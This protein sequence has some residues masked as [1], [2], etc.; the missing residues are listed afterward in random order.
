MQKKP[1]YITTSIAYVNGEPHIG[2]A[3]ELLEADALARYHRLKG[4]DV[5][6]LTGTDEHGSKLAQ[7]ATNLNMTPQELCDKNAAKFLELTKAL[8]CTNDDFIRTSDQKRHWPAVN[9]LWKTLV[10]KGDIY[11]D[12]YEGL[13]CIGCEKFITEKELVDGKCPLHDREPEKLKEENYFFRL[14]KYSK[15]IGELIR[16][17]ELQ[18]LPEFRAHEILN[19]IDEGLTDVSFSR[20]KHLLDWGVP[21]P[22]D[23]NQVMYVWCDALTNYI[24]ALGYETDDEK[25]KKYWPE[26]THVI[27]KDIVRFHAAI[28][29]GMLLSAGIPLPKRELV[30]GW[31]NMKGERMS[32]SKGNIISPF[33]LIE[34]YGVDAL[35]YYLLSEIPMGKDGDF[36]YER[37]EEKYTADLANNLG[38]LVNRVTV[39]LQKYCGGKVAKRNESYCAEVVTPAWKQYHEKMEEMMLDEAVKVAWSLVDFANKFIEEK[40]PWALSKEGKKDEV[41]EILGIL[42]ELVAHISAMIYPFIPVSAKKISDLFSKEIILFDD[43]KNFVSEGMEVRTDEPLFKKLESVEGEE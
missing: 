8:H 29:I 39:M 19:I 41:D 3:M 34:K 18:I 32:K 36:T 38:N 11:K 24:S 14:S 17:K 22:D 35:R 28:W 2:F 31:I 7:T 12:A 10:A 1:F 40:K 23:E 27:G 37:F 21:V 15:R 4:D 5:F 16:S 25:F 33:A 20:P 42:V 9:K 26:C 13:Y 43:L 30:H 6:F